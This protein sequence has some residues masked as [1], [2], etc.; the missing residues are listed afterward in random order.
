MMLAI[1]ATA[2]RKTAAT[3]Y[4]RSG[5]HTDMDHAVLLPEVAGVVVTDTKTGQ[6]AFFRIRAALTAQ[7][8]QDPRTDPA[9]RLR[10]TNPAI[11]RTSALSMA[12]AGIMATPAA[13]VQEECADL[14]AQA[15]KMDAD[16]EALLTACSDDTATLEY[17]AI[18]P[19]MLRAMADVLAYS[20]QISYGHHVASAGERYMVTEGERALAAKIAEDP[21]PFAQKLALAV[22]GKAVVR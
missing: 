21:G 20:L 2:A 13:R 12:D 19:K 18:R 10:M 7:R 22:Q 3:R 9:F 6:D 14:Q 8:I 16:R 5:G 15:A 11:R 17:L 1:D 4:L